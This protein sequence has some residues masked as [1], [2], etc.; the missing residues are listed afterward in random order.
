MI[1][2]AIMAFWSEGPRTAMSAMAR[3]MA[4][5]ASSASMTRMI[6]ASVRPPV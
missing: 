4:G 2:M 1:P 3:R 6:R 5:K